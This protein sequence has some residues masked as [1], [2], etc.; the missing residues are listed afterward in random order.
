M[1][2]NREI[3]KI[4]RHTNRLPTR[5]AIL[6]C[7]QNTSQ[8]NRHRLNRVT[9]IGALSNEKSATH[10]RGS[11]RAVRGMYGHNLEQNLRPRNVQFQVGKKPQNRPKRGSKNARR[12]LR[13]CAPM[14][15]D[16]PG[17]LANASRE[18]TAIRKMRRDRNMEDIAI[19]FRALERAVAT[20]R[21]R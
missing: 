7:A 17:R 21:L 18:I 8:P 11:R 15:V 6:S 1:F 2:R 14:P 3:Q 20:A 16:E 10:G 4:A 9:R 13:T 5:A 12:S 19:A